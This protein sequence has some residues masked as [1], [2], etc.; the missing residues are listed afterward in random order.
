MTKEIVA[1][2]LFPELRADAGSV[3]HGW[4]RDL[5]PL[6]RSITGS[7]L[8]DTLSYLND[9][10]PG[11]Q[12]HSVSSGVHV[13]DWCVPDEWNVR[14]AFVATT[15]GERLVDFRQSNLHV[16]SYSTPIDTVLSKSEL[17]P[18]L[19]FR[20]DLK[21]AI[22]YLT[23]Y[24]E[25]NWGICLS[26]SQ[27]DS[28]G[29]GPFRVVIDSTLRPGELNYGD[30]LIP[31]D[32]D[33]E[34]LLTTYV[35]HPSMANNELS[36]PVVLTA[37]AR[38]L[39]SLPERHYSYRIYFG[40]ETIGA[41][42]YLAQH[43]A[44]LR[45]HVR[46][47]WVVTCV[48]DDRG[49]S[50]LPSRK[51]NSLSDRV[52]VAALDDLG[53]QY[54]KYTFADR[55][56]DE[57]QW[58][59]PTVDLPVSSLM[60]SKYGTYPEYHTSLDDLTLVTPQGLEGGL[61]LLL[62]AISILECNVFP[63]ATTLGEPHLSKRNLYPTLGGATGGAPARN[64]LDLMSMADGEHDLVDITTESGTIFSDSYRALKDLSGLGLL[65]TSRFPFGMRG[66]V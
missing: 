46:A 57:R 25:P 10:I 33:E 15:A 8:R 50:F 42:A 19:H 12:I 7:G 45:Q 18:H 40:P 21:E 27:F 3:L 22:P 17:E 5:W 38:W 28:L 62:R 35:C 63:R 47:G 41:I 49:Y 9:L 36:G 20:E 51:G 30:L 53:L 1:P 29:P 4:M 37:I 32:S 2:S 54:Q 58:C 6:P 48:G 26:K 13:G 52:S 34:V 31:G 24:Y 64:L 44:H 66:G 65:T 60:R 43:A 16:V 59:W 61:A 23:S 56:S 14:D 11:L 55:G 39:C